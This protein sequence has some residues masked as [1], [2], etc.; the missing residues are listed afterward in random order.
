ML[1]LICG[2]VWSAAA[3]QTKFEMDAGLHPWIRALSEVGWQTGQ[4]IKNRSA[5]TSH[6][7]AHLAEHR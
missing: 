3:L 7:N 4:E 6:T 5:E 1:Y 2:Y